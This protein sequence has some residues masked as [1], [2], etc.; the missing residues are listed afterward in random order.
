MTT[1]R[2]L[3]LLGLVVL[4]GCPPARG[5]DDDDAADDDDSAADDDDATGDDDDATGDDDDA[6][7]D[8]DDATGDDDDATGGDC[9]IDLALNT[10]NTTTCGDPW[11]ESGVGLQFRMGTCGSICAGEA[12]STGVWV[13]PAELHGDFGT[14][15]CAPSQVSV[16]F[17][18]Y[19]GIGAVDVVLYDASG[20]VIASDTNTTTGSPEL[21]TLTA[22]GAVG[23]GISGCETQVLSVRID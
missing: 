15:D 21:V 9:N 13:Y 7:G 10:G 18:D 23:F 14:L 1:M 2:L 17:N 4:M 19:T 11:S 12:S 20:A 6:T 8:D 5:R 22:Q 3:L 16:E